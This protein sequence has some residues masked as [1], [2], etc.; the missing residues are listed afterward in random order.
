MT[1][2]RVT[3]VIPTHNRRESVLRAVA[4]LMRERDEFGE[5]D[6]VVSCDRCEDG[7][8]EALRKAFGE[9]IVVLRSP[10]PGAAAARNVGLRAAHGGL[11]IFLD[12]DMEPERGFVSAHV[13]AHETSSGRA[14]AVSG[15][16]EPILPEAPAPIQRELA[17]SYE[18]F[19][20]EL[21]RLGRAAS[22][23]DLVGGN[24]SIET[25]R[26]ESVGGFDETFRFARD[27][28]ELGVRLLDRG[29]RIEFQ[30]SARVRMHMTTTA[31]EI[32]GRAE[33]RGRNDVRLA[34][35]FPRFAERLPFQR[36]FVRPSTLL[37]WR[38]VWPASR[39]AAGLI[40]ALRRF[41][42]ENI[43]LINWE[44]AA[45]YMVGLR[46]EAGSWRTFC[47]LAGGTSRARPPGTA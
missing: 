15:Y 19:F 18:D 42:R 20:R 31:D 6:V 36:V 13:S 32:V 38:L 43:R 24:F 25:A 39:V 1:S 41:A 10:T 28:F 34:R 33:D 16:C 27:D 8:E 26:L 5:V 22:P 47:R 23:G 37:R 44:Y 21:E 17:R 35:T 11:A 4:A 30:P 12:D 7:T 29:F 46:R 14:I 3:V 45:R 2:R 9:R 40:S